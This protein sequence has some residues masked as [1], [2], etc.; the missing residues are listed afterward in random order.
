MD[1]TGMACGMGTGGMAVM[2]I[3]GLLVVVALVLAVAALVKYLRS[4]PK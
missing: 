4:G 1:C 3:I 2:T